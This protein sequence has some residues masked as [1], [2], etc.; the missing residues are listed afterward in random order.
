MDSLPSYRPQQTATAV[1]RTRPRA[2]LITHLF[3]ILFCLEIGF[4]L[5]FLPW[6]FL[7]DEN[8]FFSITPNWNYF[9]FS[10]YLRGAVSGLGLL[11]MWIGLT[12]AWRLRR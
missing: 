3:F 9:W 7:W 6:T 12:E 4:V 11:N 2:H 5:F 1:A 10:A 8:Y